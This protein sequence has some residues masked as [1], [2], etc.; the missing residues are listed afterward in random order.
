[1]TIRITLDNN[2]VIEVDIPLEAWNG[3]Y[4]RALANGTMIEIQDP[5]GHITSINP[6]RV[7]LVEATESPATPQGHH[8]EAV[9]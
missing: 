7:N 4:Q 8:R 2:E 5:S 9:A 1:M 3:A 6:N